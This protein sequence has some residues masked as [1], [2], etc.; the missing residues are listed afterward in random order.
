MIDENNLADKVEET[1]EEPVALSVNDLASIRKILDVA[2][3][4]GAFKTEEFQVVGAVYGK[5]AAFVDAAI[6]ASQQQEEASEEETQTEA[7][8]KE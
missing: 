2:S 5:L 8:T 3:Q 7:E 4:R 1:A 6:A